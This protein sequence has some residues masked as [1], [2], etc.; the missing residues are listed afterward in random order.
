M[1]RVLLWITPA[2]ALAAVVGLIGHRALV[3]RRTASLRTTG[4]LAVSTPTVEARRLAAR[5]GHAHWPS[6]PR[7]HGGGTLAVEGAHPA[8]ASA[9]ATSGAAGSAIVPA[10]TAPVLKPEEAAIRHKLEPLL[11]G[12]KDTDLGFVVCEP[13][14]APPADGADEEPSA[15]DSPPKDLDQPVCRA[16]VQAR[17]RNTLAQVV[18]EAS[19]LYEGHV[20]VEVREHMTAFNGLLYEA[21]LRVGTDDPQPIPSDI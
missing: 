6:G 16:R 7:L 9:T 17:D 15:F 2:L 8:P 4:E 20:A 3:Q 21:D 12:R 1:K 13:F 19:S 11:A 10:S 18:R 14:I 5:P